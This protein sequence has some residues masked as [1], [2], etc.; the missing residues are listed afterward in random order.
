MV[1]LLHKLFRIQVCHVCETR[2]LCSLR[3]GVRALG[4]AVLV[5][6][7]LRPVGSVR[8]RG[9]RPR[10][11]MEFI[12][13]YSYASGR[14]QAMMREAAANVFVASPDRSAEGDYGWQ[15]ADTY[16]PLHTAPVSDGPASLMSGP[17][18]HEAARESTFHGA[19]YSPPVAN[20][21][22]SKFGGLSPYRGTQKVY[23]QS[24]P[25]TTGSHD[26]YA[27][28]VATSP[29]SPPQGSTPSYKRAPQQWDVPTVPAFEGKRAQ[30]TGENVALRGGS[31]PTNFTYRSES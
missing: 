27:R 22:D 26:K 15:N 12:K 11:T 13:P 7:L 2:N 4:C 10:D 30:P 16:G 24:S 20:A 19:V 29:W 23:T 1:F 6:L 3:P 8:R 21:F 5:L 31:W 9:R 18:V 28:G 17:V 25:Q 14:Q